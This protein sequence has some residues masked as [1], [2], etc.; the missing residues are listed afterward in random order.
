M[1]FRRR[2]YSKRLF[3]VFP[4]IG[5]ATVLFF[6]N[7]S[8]TSFSTLGSD[9]ASMN[10]GGNN[11]SGGGTGTGTGTGPDTGVVPDTGGYEQGKIYG[12]CTMQLDGNMQVAHNGLIDSSGN[13]VASYDMGG[14]QSW[15]ISLCPN[16]G[17][18]NN[19]QCASGFKPVMRNMV[20]MNCAT[21]K[22]GFCKTYWI[23]F[24]CVKL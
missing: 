11:S 14:S 21:T 19:V 18:P 1:S 16:S 13:R 2:V 23:T 10:S 12:S 6:Q 9:L 4:A 17:N 22:A 15:P 20:Q 3:L 5:I 8:N 7:C 24:N